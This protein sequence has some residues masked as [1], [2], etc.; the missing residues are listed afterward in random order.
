M[1]RTT[2]TVAAVG[3]HTTPQSGFMPLGR[4]TVDRFTHLLLEC[5]E[6]KEVVAL[7]RHAVASA[8]SSDTSG[9]RPGSAL[10]H[11]SRKASAAHQV[12]TEW[13]TDPEY[14]DARGRPRALPKRGARS[15]EALMRRF[16]PSVDVD[17]ALDYL[18]Q[19]GTVERGGSRYLA[20]RRWASTHGSQGPE[21]VLSLRAVADLLRTMEHNVLPGE[22]PMGWFQ[23]VAE[24][25]QVPVSKLP[26][27]ERQLERK[28]MPFLLWWDGY[29][30]Q[31]A[32][33]G[34][35]GEPTVRF[36]IGVYRFQEGAEDAERARR[37]RGNGLSVRNSAI[38]QGR[39][40]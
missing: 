32:R 19:T 18:I 3:R 36:G 12:V 22:G 20:V 26:E 4:E 35:A 11:W 9:T 34:R 30:R 33:Q 25:T 40:S 21:R 7:L 14:V 10:D 29:L 2:A 31:C 37:R 16:N 13:W 17:D 24:N 39:K 8:E 5:L 28:G 15:V 38:A 1:R 27:I 23:R 6:R